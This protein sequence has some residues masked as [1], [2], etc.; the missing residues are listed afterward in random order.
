MIRALLGTAAVTVAM[1]LPTGPGHADA[2][3][4][5]CKEAWQAPH[6]QGADW[7]RAHGWTVRARLLVGPHG[8]VRMHRLPHCR[9][10]DGSGQRSACTWNIGRRVDGDGQGLS[11]WV[12]PGDRVHY[13][14]PERPLGEPTPPELAD[15][16]AEGMVDE[17]WD[18][19][20]LDENHTHVRCPDG[21]LTRVYGQ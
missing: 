3:Y 21:Y 8:V 14:W 18:T 20:W 1:V 5:G 12:G 9:E 15:A 13:V 2:P 7:C 17:N 19:C 4:G 10:E 11:Y 16:L 6:S